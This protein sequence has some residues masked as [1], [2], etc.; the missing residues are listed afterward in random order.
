MKKL[1][2]EILVS[3]GVKTLDD[4]L[5]ALDETTSDEVGIDGQP[6]DNH[7]MAAHAIVE[8]V[9][10]ADVETLTLYKCP[11]CGAMASNKDLITM[12]GVDHFLCCG[13]P[14][15]GSKVIKITYEAVTVDVKEE[16]YTPITLV[17]GRLYK[18]RDMAGVKKKY[19]GK[20]V[21]AL[22][23]NEGLVTVELLEGPEAGIELLTFANQLEELDTAS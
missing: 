10:K 20:K 9:A 18:I 3:H 21:A 23:V 11:E 22:K 13:Y 19:R 7:L 5:L 16:G 4:V 12:G 1:I 15:G 6:V 2:D 17:K 14:V 8:S